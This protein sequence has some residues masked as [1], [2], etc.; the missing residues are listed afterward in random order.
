MKTIQNLDEV[1]VAIRQMLIQQ[2]ELSPDRVLNALS[3]EGTELDKLLEEQIY[4]SI[5]QNDTTL[6]FQLNTLP[7]E[8][9]V[10]MEEGDKY[11]ARDQVCSMTTL[12][13]SN[14]IV[15]DFVIDYSITY[16]KIYRLSVIMYGILS[17]DL[18]AKLV[19]RLRSSNVRTNLYSS[20]IYVEEVSNPT[21]INEFKNN[22]VWLRNDIGID[23]GV[24]YSVSQIS[25]PETFKTVNTLNIIMGGTKIYE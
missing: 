4:D 5:S 18:A 13:G 21:V 6:L 3:L 7:S 8:S 14:T 23:L 20:G 24:K 17:S 2:S 22:T 11:T 16:Y 19:A 9:D 12:T 1:I 15:G 25:L 10:S